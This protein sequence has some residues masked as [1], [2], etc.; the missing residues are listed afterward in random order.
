M[1]GVG[2]VSGA[3]MGGL[4]NDNYD[5]FYSFYVVAIFGLFI[6]GLGITM[7]TNIEGENIDMLELS[8]Y[9]RSFVILKQVWRGM[10]LQELNRA[11][12][13]FVLMGCIV[14]SFGDCVYYYQMDVVGFS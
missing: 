7:D 1:Y 5:P 13:Y 9:S 11:V 8:F 3:F 12:F 10:Q 14:P 4:I 2:G 6:C